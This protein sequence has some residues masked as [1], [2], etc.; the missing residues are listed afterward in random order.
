MSNHK[1][2][3]IHFVMFAKVKKKVQ[4]FKS[5]LAENNWIVFMLM[6][7]YFYL[8]AHTFVNHIVVCE[9][10]FPLTAGEGNI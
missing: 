4:Q 8:Y 3:L 9:D 5:K 2:S 1:K 7:M 6:H 10:C